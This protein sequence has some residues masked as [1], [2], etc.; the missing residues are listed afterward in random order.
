[1][2]YLR[3]VLTLPGILSTGGGTPMKT[4]NA[5]LLKADAAPTIWLAT[6][7]ATTLQRL[8]NDTTRPLAHKLD[9]SGLL[10]LQEKRTPTYERVA[11]LVIQTDQLS[12]Q[13]IVEQIKKWLFNSQL[14]LQKD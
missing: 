8:Q 10:S 7:G 4:T 6:T 1:E 5:A 13:Q 14:N 2:Q 12:P 9:T 11:D 3:H